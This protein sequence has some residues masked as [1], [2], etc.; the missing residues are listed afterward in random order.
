MTEANIDI[1]GLGSSCVDD[2]LIVESYP[3]RNE[4]IFVLD[5]KRLGGG[6]TGSALVA[7]AR[8]GCACGLVIR[9]DHG[10]IASFIR[11]SLSREGILLHEQSPGPEFAPFHSII[12]V[13]KGSGERTIFSKP[14]T[15]VTPEIGDAEYALLDRAKCLFVDFI[16]AA[17]FCISCTKRMTSAWFIFAGSNWAAP[18]RVAA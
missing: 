16:F 4:K 11:D 8:L 7:A 14:A 12:I 9:L 3:G 6:L 15:D 1:L 13:E 10:E 2:L 17:M 18:W 5:A